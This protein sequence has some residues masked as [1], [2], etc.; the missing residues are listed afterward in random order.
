METFNGVWSR[1]DVSILTLQAPEIYTVSLHCAEIAATKI[2]DAHELQVSI[3]CH[4][5]CKGFFCGFS[6]SGIGLWS[7]CLFSRDSRQ[8]F[9]LAKYA[10]Y[11]SSFVC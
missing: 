6:G 8:Q 5:D 10:S 9:C 3:F 7:K 1:P 11:N 4:N 2:L